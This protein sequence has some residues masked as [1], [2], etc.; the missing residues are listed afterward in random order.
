MA[1]SKFR[2]L[3]TIAVLL[4]NVFAQ[5]YAQEKPNIIIVLVDNLGYGELGCYGGGETR[6]APTPRIDQL[7]TEGMRF[8]N[9]NMEPQCTPSRS[10]LLTGRFAIRSGTYAVPFGGVAD[11][12]TQWEITMGESFSAAGYT[13][14]YYGKWHLGSHDG[15]LPNDQGFDEWYGIPRTTDEAM[16]PGSTGYSESIMPPE[17]IM[18]GQKGGKSKNLKVYD[19]EQRRLIDAEI[20]RRSGT[21]M[22]QHA[23]DSKPFFVFAA[24]TQAHIPSMPNPAFVGKTGNGD[25]ADM[26]TEMDHNVGQLLDETDHLGISQKTIFIFLSDNGAEYIKPWDGWAGPWRGQYFTAWEGGIRVPFIIR[27]PGKIPAGKV[28][29]EIVHGVDV[30]PTLAKMVGAKVPTDRPIDGLDMSNFFLGKVEKSGREGFP[31]WV[32]NRLQAVKWRHFKVHFYDQE[33]MM[34]PPLKLAIPIMFDLYTNPMEDKGKPITTSWVI[35][36]VLKMIGEFEA[37]TKQFPLIPMG[38]PDPYSPPKQ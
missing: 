35:G 13:T 28:T 3:N 27:W 32:D 34:S 23:K 16:W 29:N 1:Q 38:T 17:Q 7:A 8:T 4:I 26:L 25:W 5:V 11:G 31:V 24:M 10:S 14:A 2:R 36:P 6:G 21:Y 30:F 12:L 19:L 18:E 20:T 9:M 22:E 15:R 37:S 33:N